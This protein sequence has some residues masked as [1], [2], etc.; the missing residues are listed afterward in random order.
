MHWL[1]YLVTLSRKGELFQSFVTLRPPG[2]ACVVQN[3]PRVLF[4]IRYISHVAGCSECP[5]ILERFLVYLGE[6]REQSWNDLR[7]RSM[8]TESERRNGFL[9]R[10]EFT[11]ISFRKKFLYCIE[12]TGIMAGTV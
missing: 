8:Y 12:T 9:T 5:R 2:L 1:L 10:N 4:D 11:S 7:C 6:M 3:L